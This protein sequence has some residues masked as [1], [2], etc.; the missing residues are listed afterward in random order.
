M[1]FKKFSDN[2]GGSVAF[3]KA[4]NYGDWDF[5]FVMEVV[6]NE[7]HMTAIEVK[8]YGKYTVLLCVV[9]PE[10]YGADKSRQLWLNQIDE[11][12]ILKDITSV[13]MCYEL[14]SY[15]IYAPLKLVSGNNL[16]VATQIVRNE[17]KLIQCLFGFYM[18]RPVNGIGNTGWDFVSGH[19]G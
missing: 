4:L 6:R 2:D 19:I 12:Y 5:R 14:F 1:Q 13:Q 11:E 15:G 10:A 17:L 18:D 8:E 3:S 7:D 9:S 16:D